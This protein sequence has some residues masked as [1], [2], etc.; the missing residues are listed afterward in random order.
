[1]AKSP[2]VPLATIIGRMTRPRRR[3][4]P[5]LH[6]IIRP[7]SSQLS[8]HGRPVPDLDVHLKRWRYL[9]HASYARQ[10]PT[11][12]IGHPALGSLHGLALVG[13]S[14]ACRAAVS[15][16]RAPSDRDRRPQANDVTEEQSG[17]RRRRLRSRDDRR[18]RWTP[19]RC[20][21]TRVSGRNDEVD[22]A[23]LI[24]ALRHRM[25]SSSAVAAG[26]GGSL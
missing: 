2:P 17:A 13:A 22:A 10:R 21:G 23:E 4:R 20:A 16:H 7:P 8:A 24:G 18:F 5:V 11:H 3:R 14:G 19:C 1:M 26:L 9:D 25:R 15:L 12:L 6:Y